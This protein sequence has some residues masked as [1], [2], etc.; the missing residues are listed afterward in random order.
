MLLNTFYAFVKKI[1]KEWNKI[2]DQRWLS[3]RGKVMFDQNKILS[4]LYIT[5]FS[6]PVVTKDFQEKI[7]FGLCL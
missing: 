5:Q 1:N 2:K 7:Q 4:V 3:R 6:T